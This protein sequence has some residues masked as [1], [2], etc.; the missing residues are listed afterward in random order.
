MRWVFITAGFVALAASTTM[1]LGAVGGLSAGSA[2]GLIAMGVVLAVGA[3]AVGYALASRYVGIAIVIGLGMVA[4][5]VGA[6]IQTAQRVTASRELQRAPIAALVEQRSAALAELAAAEAARVESP[7]RQRLDAAITAKSVAA[8]TV[9][10]NAADKGCRENC[11]VLLQAAV[12]AAGREVEAAR[13]DLA[14]GE[15]KQAMAIAT[16]TEKA[17]AA[18]ASLPPPRS[19]TPFADYSGIPE[20]LLDVVEALALSLAINL[21]ASALIALGVKMSPAKAAGKK[22]PPAA[23]TIDAVAVTPRDHAVKFGLEVLAPGDENMPVA[24]LHPAYL[25]WCRAKNHQP[26]APRDIGKALLDLFGR[27]GVEIAEIGGRPHVLR[28]RIRDQKRVLGSMTQ[29]GVN[30]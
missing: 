21:P 30:A 6:M 23:E 26:F 11:R 24:T 10:E 25:E 19:A 12:D 1:S 20:W 22:A 17:K 28:A 29:V 16:R 7:S 2:P 27:T 3:A 14:E 4:G 9:A 5:E 8:R 15:K 18:V 13:T